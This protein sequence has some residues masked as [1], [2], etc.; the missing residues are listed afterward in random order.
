MPDP[1]AKPIPSAPPI[2]LAYD[3]NEPMP[4]KQTVEQ[5]PQLSNPFLIADTQG[6][7]VL[8]KIPVTRI[9][10][11]QVVDILYEDPQQELYK[12]VQLTSGYYPATAIMNVYESQ[13]G[14]SFEYVDD[15]GNVFTK[16]A[17]DEILGLTWQGIPIM[18]RFLEFNA[19]AG[20][21]SMPQQQPMF[22]PDYMEPPI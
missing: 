4:R 10:T 17:K 1:R 5:V 19:H 6:K 7:S 16:V 18:N 22:W 12:T 15:W 11:D 21:G 20:S 3:L 13:G 8:T 9:Y 2:F 14:R